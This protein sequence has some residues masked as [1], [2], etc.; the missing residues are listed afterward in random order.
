M[1]Y[2]AI[3][4]GFGIVFLAVGT[5]F[6]QD[7]LV[8]VFVDGGFVPGLNPPGGVGNCWDEEEQ[9]TRDKVPGANLEC[10]GLET[11]EPIFTCHHG[12]PGGFSECEFYSTHSY[13]LVGDCETSTQA[14]CHHCPEGSNIFCMIYKLWATKQGPNCVQ[15]CNEWQVFFQGTCTD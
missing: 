13:V 6:S 11:C 4:L 12:D 2:R 10:E 7:R 3:V 8:I 9:E 5:L 14:T 15:P 1:K